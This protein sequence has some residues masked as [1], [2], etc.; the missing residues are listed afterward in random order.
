MVDIH[1]RNEILWKFG[2]FSF[3]FLN[4]F[5]Y[6]F[7]LYFVV[8]YEFHWYKKTTF[9][10]QIYKTFS[11]TVLISKIYNMLDYIA[12]YSYLVFT[13]FY[14]GSWTQTPPYLP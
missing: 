14:R 4:G 9:T 2:G 10:E 1:K 3:I 6:L 8:E 7:S 5:I 11:N 13:L 12:F